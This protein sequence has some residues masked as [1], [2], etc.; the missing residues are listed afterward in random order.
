MLYKNYI[1][2]FNLA[3][4]EEIKELRRSGGQKTYLSNG[5]YLG[6]RNGKYVYAFI[7][8]TEIR[9][10]D[11]TPVDLEF[12]KEKINGILISVEGFDLIIGIS[13][14]IGKKVATAI[15][16]TAPWFL[17]E[18]LKERLQ[19][20]DSSNPNKQ[21]AEKLLGIRQISIEND[22]KNANNSV[23][24]LQSRYGLKIQSNEYQV[25]AV[26][27]VLN[28]EVSFIWGP[29]GT[30][31]TSTL[32]L[33]VASLSLE[34]ESVLVVAHSNTAVDTAMLSIA[35]NL[36]FAPIYNEG[37]VIRYG[38]PSSSKLKKYPNLSVREIVRKQNANLI[39]EIENLEGLRKRLLQKAKNQDLIE[40]E[41]TY[42]R[43]QI[44]AIRVKIKPLKDSLKQKEIELVKKAQ[45]VGCTLSKAT[46]SEEI[47]KRKFDAVIIDEASM[48]YI[49]HC[50]F[51][52]TLANYRIAI[53]G[54]FRQLGPI[55]QSESKWLQT[56]IFE[57]SGVTEK[58]K[59]GESDS[60]MV[61]LKTQ[62]RMH[63]NISALPN[64]LYY[65]N[66]L[67]NGEGTLENNKKIVNKHPFP[68]HSTVFYDIS[69]LPAYC[70]SDKQS[71]SRF[72]IISA[73]ISVSISNQY[74]RDVNSQT[75]HNIGIITPYS[76][77]SR[78]INKILQDLDLCDHIK[79]STVH[80]FQGDEQD[81]IVFDS[82]EGNPQSKASK[83]L[84]GGDNS[85]AARLSNVAISRAKGKF[86]GVINSKFIQTKLD[87]TFSAFGKF[88]DY[89]K[90]TSQVEI[91]KL[92]E[93]FN[94]LEEVNFFNDYKD[95]MKYIQDDLESAKDE[96]SIRW[97]DSISQAQLP[98]T[99]LKKCSSKNIRFFITGSASKSISSSLKNCRLWSNQLTTD[100]GL[101]GIDRKVL[102]IYL[103]PNRENTSPL[104]RLNL[105]KTVKL[106]Y[107]F[108]ELVPQDDQG[109]IVNKI[110]DGKNPLGT[111]AQC[112]NPLWLM[113]TQYGNRIGCTKIPTHEN[114]GRNISAQDIT[115]L[116]NFMGKSC[117][118]CGSQLVGRK[119]KSDISVFLACSK[120]GCNGK[121][122]LRDLLS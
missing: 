58:V 38:N 52:S 110:Q 17:L 67:Q 104:I 111:C 30:G 114:G 71:H 81:L 25:A 8:D 100:I 12:L 102:W 82:V 77:Q 54:D 20:G 59:K 27:N 91:S 18:K 117:S 61:L 108:L 83:L 86:V 19:D 51:V 101:I 16:F 70:Y 65:S 22:K 45:V 13:K 29:P 60:R 23:Q 47:Y 33:T 103:S 34:G 14:N 44:E 76:A 15:L 122:G 90:K 50:T 119:S 92:H 69:R 79:V 74:E 11:D 121:L 64:K 107:S 72:N 113:D 4:N 63:P 56:D 32:G 39:I 48:A 31:K 73:L 46:I 40:N 43:E 120:Q 98:I 109:S 93:C 1:D 41:G 49:P 118:K 68:N 112:G 55:S 35:K 42:I 95:A 2:E 62:Y 88:V 5:N 21:L 66:Q 3:L 84:Q 99:S 36:E 85:T 24:S 75:G 96:I 115:Q 10:P 28:K 105:S 80:R 116:A 26:N 94:G 97:L 9:F 7:S 37:L 57:E 106:L 53:F 89:F 6:K 87:S 78:L